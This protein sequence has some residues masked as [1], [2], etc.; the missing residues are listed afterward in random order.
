MSSRKL[1]AADFQTSCLACCTYFVCS[2]ER[3]P[4]EVLCQDVETGGA[5]EHWLV[6]LLLGHRRMYVL[7]RCRAGNLYPECCLRSCLPAGCFGFWCLPCLYGKNASKMRSTS[8]SGPGCC[9]A[10]CPCFTC[11]ANESLF[12]LLH[13]PIFA[14]L[15]CR[16]CTQAAYGALRTHKRA[17][18][19]F[20]CSV[21]WYIARRSA[22]QIQPA[23]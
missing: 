3:A 12:G 16:A 11:S 17:C 2:C 20:A 5:L 23:T 4:L 1:Q 22:Y 21:C 7:L 10:C 9:Y 13:C 15:S 14:V 6:W 18:S 19:S 8:C